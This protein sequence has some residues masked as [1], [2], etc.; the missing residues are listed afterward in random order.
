MANTE[1]FGF[2]LI[3]NVYDLSKSYNGDISLID[4]VLK[5]VGSAGDGSSV[6][7]SE[8]SAEFAGSASIGGTLPAGST[9]YYA[10]TH[11][12]PATG[13]Q[14]AASDEITV[15][16]LDEVFSPSAP[17]FSTASS[18]GS[19]TPG[20][21]SYVLS[22]W[23]VHNS[24]ETSAVNSSSVT[25]FSGAGNDQVI[26]LTLPSLGDFDGY[27]VYRRR[28]G[29]S[30]F[31]YIGSVTTTELV[32]DGLAVEDC[33]R[34]APVSSNIVSGNLVNLSIDSLPSGYHWKIYR[35]TVS[36]DYSNS[37]IATITDGSLTYADM[38]DVVQFKSPPVETP[39]LVPGNV[40]LRSGSGSPSSGD[41]N[42]GDWWID[43]SAGDLY[44]PKA[45]GSWPSSKYLIGSLQ[46][47]EIS[48]AGL[49]SVDVITAD[50]SLSCSTLSHFISFANGANWDITFDDINPGQYAELKIAVYN[51]FGG[52]GGTISP[53]FEGISVDRVD[54]IPDTYARIFTVYVKNIAGTITSTWDHGITVDSS[55]PDY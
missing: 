12:D 37:L 5:V 53:T 47:V 10:Y 20:Q 52:G 55:S 14:S 50:S 23:K 36:G 49:F 54:D 28:P 29:S 4:V 1:N 18:G 34:F 13:L 25:L 7:V 26:T 6:T 24:F 43:T 3:E 21:Y 42:D 8:P 15:E 33:E 32:D 38:G 39:V 48:S 11:V 31:Y 45:S 46:K 22:G 2:S 44:G 16:T 17:S 19:L 51:G 40:G 35:S 9:Y 41:G 27:N 30:S